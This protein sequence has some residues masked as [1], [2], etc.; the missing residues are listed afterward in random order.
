MYLAGAPHPNRDRVEVFLRDRPEEHYV[1]SVEVYQEILRRYVAIDRR[2]AIRD[3]FRL[4]DDLAA[5]VFPVTRVHVDAAREIA[6]RRLM[7]SARGC[8]HLA[9][10]QAHGVERVLTFDQGFSA[11]PGIIRF[12]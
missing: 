2:S 10:M 8:L 6:E 5:S 3:A 1:T 12:P 11:V 4:L 7:L 9:V